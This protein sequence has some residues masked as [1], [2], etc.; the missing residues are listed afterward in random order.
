LAGIV[1]VVGPAVQASAT[2]RGAP[3]ALTSAA[4]RA[5]TASSTAVVRQVDANGFDTCVLLPDGTPQCWGDGFLD[6]EDQPTGTYTE[7][8]VGGGGGCGL[9]AASAISCWSLPVEGNEYPPPST[10]QYT[11]L[12]GGDDDDCALSTAGAMTC[13]G[14][15]SVSQPGPFTK[16]S[17]GYGGGCAIETGGSLF[18]F[19]YS[20]GS[21]YLSPPTGTYAAVA[22]GGDFACAIG[23]DQEI[24]CWG[25][26]TYG[27][28]DPPDGRYVAISAGSYFACALSTADTV[29][30]WG[31]NSSGQTDA[32]AGQFTAISAGAYHACGVAADGYVRCW[33]D[34]N[35]GQLGAAPYFDPKAADEFAQQGGD[36]VAT[37]GNSGGGEDGTPPA[38]FSISSGTPPDLTL[39][40]QQGQLS[41]LLTTP[42]TFR[43]TV[44]V[45]NVEGAASARVDM[46]VIGWFL[47]FKSPGS[48]AQIGKGHRL[49]VQF[50]YGTYAGA[51]VAA[52]YAATLR[53]RVT[54]S[55]HS[56]GTH[57]IVTGNCA[58]SASVRAFTCSL[59]LPRNLPTGRKHHYFLTAYQLSESGYTPCPSGK[60]R[61]D[62]NPAE[63]YF[64]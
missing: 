61:A 5:T 20:F 18:C 9:T 14:P 57:P 60:T 22:A 48:V 36:F 11:Q 51:Q 30:C 62:R 44:S 49:T 8:G 12:S 58:Y 29:S 45:A 50:H 46:I 63:I 23:T 28:T 6:G 55:S 53:M 34:D 32:P 27:Q 25:D 31:S 16:V 33:G 24:S 1:A 38:V 4:R 19:D 37:F 42:G 52:K 26:N 64:R 39:D 3:T 2:G 35:D 43:F 59:R 7:I 41:G 15:N 54:I 13:W 56:S 47:G 17:V 21:Y 10:G 40:S